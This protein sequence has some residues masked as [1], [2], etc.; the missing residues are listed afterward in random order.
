MPRAQRYQGEIET[1][2]RGKIK[3]DRVR[4]ELSARDRREFRKD[5]ALYF[6][7]F[8][9]AHG[10]LTNAFIAPE[11]TLDSMSAKV[12]KMK[13]PVG[14]LITIIAHVEEPKRHKSKRIVLTFPE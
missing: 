8:F 12:A 10:L 5:P 14:T 11:R 13:A 4:L 3:V 1:I 9:K 2:A 7:R 6:R